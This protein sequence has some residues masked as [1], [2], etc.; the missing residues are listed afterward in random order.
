VKLTC[1]S[2]EDFP[3]EFGLSTAGHGALS[4]YCGFL[5]SSQR[6]SMSE[7]IKIKF[8]AHLLETTAVQSQ[9]GL[10]IAPDVRI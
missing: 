2:R 4:D 9:K 8:I 1:L 5:P 6:T 3:C 10:S 7:E